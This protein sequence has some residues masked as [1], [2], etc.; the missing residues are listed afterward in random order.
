MPEGALLL[1]FVSVQRLVELI[2]ARR[3]TDR[4]LAKG[5]VEFGRSHYPI[6]VALHLGWLGGLWWIAA[7]RPV[8]PVLVAMFAVLQLGRVW[9]IGTLGERWTTRV[10]VVP[11]EQLIAGGPFRLV[12]HPNYLIVVAEIAVVPLAL[13]LPYYAA[14]FSVLNAALLALRIT[15]ENAALAWATAGHRADEASIVPSP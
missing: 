7:D 14:L 13:G 3:N 10:I 5:G 4:L 6:M 15:V 11:G 2:W 9:V 8:D 12:R 1:A